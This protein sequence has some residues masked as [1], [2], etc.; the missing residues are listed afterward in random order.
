M[1]R[2]ESVTVCGTSAK[3][4]RRQQGAM[5]PWR[6]RPHPPY[7]GQ[8]PAVQSCFGGR[9]LLDEI[10]MP[11]RT[12]R[13]ISIGEATQCRKG[14]VP[15]WRSAPN[16]HKWWQFPA[17][18]SCFAGSSTSN[19]MEI[20]GKQRRTWSLWIS[21]LLSERHWPYVGEATQCRSQWRRA[22]MAINA[23]NSRSITCHGA[24]PDVG[25]HFAGGAG[26]CIR[27]LPRARERSFRK[28]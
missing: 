12:H 10:E 23:M 3:R 25:R 11:S 2:S 1:P 20:L 27:F 14:A 21:R 22:S 24:W 16:P 17:V 6:G 7:G 9:T 18:P 4:R 15:P 28:E 26:T 19:K 5:H 8:L 13:M